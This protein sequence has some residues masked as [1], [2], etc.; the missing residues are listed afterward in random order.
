[1][2]D[3]SA[4]AARRLAATVH[5]AY[6][7]RIHSVPVIDLDFRPV[8]AEHE[9]V[10][11]LHVGRLHVSVARGST[12]RSVD[13]VFCL[14]LIGLAVLLSS[15]A[16]TS[17]IGWTPDGLAYQAK[18]LEYAGLPTEEAEHQAFALR[19][20][21]TGANGKATLTSE[22]KF[23]SNMVWFHRRV[24]V[25]EIA[26]R[27]QPVLGLRSLLAISIAAYVL[28]GVSLYAFLRL[29][30]AAPYAAGA[31]ALALLFP[32]LQRWSFDPLSDSSGLLC[33]VVALTAA[34]L[35][36]T[37]DRR[38]LAL[39]ISAI[40]IGSVT[41]ESIV[42][43]ILA[44]GLLAARRTPR[45]RSLLLSG[46]AAVGPAMLLLRY[47][48]RRSFALAAAHQ[49]HTRIDLTTLGIL[50]NWVLLVI[51]QPLGD[52]FADPVW[53]Y[54]LGLALAV[55]ALS[56]RRTIF[57]RL[58]RSSAVAGWLYLASFP[59]LS[60]LRLEFVLIPPATYG[61]A[62]LAEDVVITARKMGR[63][64]LLRA[65]GRE[66]VE[67]AQAPFPTVAPSAV[68]ALDE[69]STSL[70]QRGSSG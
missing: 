54:A 9:Q 18:A 21:V 1:L 24:L 5:L 39:W 29:R 67:S 20:Q 33:V 58:A 57:A 34:T 4:K 51:W 56:P 48:E 27:L 31:A 70:G 46:L 61:I 60:G 12:R 50:K 66:L 41:R 37:R 23:A 17:P 49:M 44:V 10:D 43:P 22:E 55:V 35:T 8:D 40:A 14:A 30:F 69:S 53:T 42:V 16:W 11:A 6:L 28:L 64:H 47:P 13:A 25:P 15:R 62:Q 52:L 45:A 7:K 19:S 63:P 36:L 65:A 59:F 3:C 68:R 32:P 38:W 26:A 2:H